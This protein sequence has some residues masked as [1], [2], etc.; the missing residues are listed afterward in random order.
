MEIE[1]KGLDRLI[2]GLEA[3]GGEGTVDE[4]VDRTLHRAAIRIQKQAKEDCPANTGKLRGSISV[5]KI[6]KG[7]AV[8][9]NVEYGV[10]VEFGTGALGDPAVPHTTRK[11][12]RYKGADGSWHTS[13]G[14]KPCPFLLPAF[15]K[16]K[17]NLPRTI[18]A[19]LTRKLN[20]VIG[21]D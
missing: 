21:H 6:P 10:Y 7:Y 4:V 20:E 11:Y 3:L 8:G 1:I 12:W 19:N 17:E 13:H 18:K 2:K 16:Y 5:E 14:M 9:T 15:N